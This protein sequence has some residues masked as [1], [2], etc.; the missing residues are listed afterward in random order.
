[1]LELVSVEMRVEVRRN[2]EGY[3]DHFPILRGID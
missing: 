2:W 3:E 1:M